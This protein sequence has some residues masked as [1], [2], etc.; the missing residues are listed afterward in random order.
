MSMI[1]D[2]RS[3]NADHNCVNAATEALRLYADL[4][5]EPRVKR[6]GMDSFS[7]L[8]LRCYYGRT[9]ERAAAAEYLYRWRLA[10]KPSDQVLNTCAR[11][12]CV[13]VFGA[14]H[15]LGQ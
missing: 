7:A 8:L 1:Q 11:N 15:L 5:P 14:P 12:P 13:S 4:Y 9:P 2:L 6:I 3:A 10:I